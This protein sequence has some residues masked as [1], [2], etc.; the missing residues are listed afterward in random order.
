MCYAWRADHLGIFVLM[1]LSGGGSILEV[2][3][4]L[5]ADFGQI[6]HPLVSWGWWS[7]GERTEPFFDYT[8]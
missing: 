1:W 4:G 8:F 2:I 5:P 7:S 3:R 6:G